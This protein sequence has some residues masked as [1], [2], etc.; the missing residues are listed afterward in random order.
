M[1]GLETF[2][3]FGNRRMVAI[4]A[5][6]WKHSFGFGTGEWQPFIS[7]PRSIALLWEQE[8]GS[9]LCLGH[10]AF[11][12]LGNWTMQPFMSGPGSI[13]LVWQ[14]ANSCL[15]HLSLQTFTCSVQALGFIH[16]IKQNEHIIRTTLVFIQI[17]SPPK[18]IFT[19]LR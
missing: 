5:W 1:L 6:A 19:V 12:L 8:N 16:E 7:G 17:N 9:L 11:T 15:F 18:T 3:W 10:E 13:Y 2:T 4:Y 14:Q